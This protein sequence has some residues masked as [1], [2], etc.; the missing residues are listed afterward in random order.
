MHPSHPTVLNAQC[1]PWGCNSELPFN[2]EVA[3]HGY[4]ME[5]ETQKVAKLSLP[6]DFGSC[7]PNLRCFMSRKEG[8]VRLKLHTG[9]LICR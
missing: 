7:V 8:G 5:G 1:E 6:S 4:G 9:G 2:A 3:E